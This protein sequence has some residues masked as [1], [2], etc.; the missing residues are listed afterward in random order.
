MFYLRGAVDPVTVAAAAIC[1]A[2]IVTLGVPVGVQ[3]L[4]AANA[5]ALGVAVAAGARFIRA[6][7]FAY[8]H[9][10]DEGW[11]DATAGLFCCVSDGASVRR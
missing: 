1:V 3:V 8:A 7:A 10:A 9:V 6:E 4:A 11:L 5:E 2:E